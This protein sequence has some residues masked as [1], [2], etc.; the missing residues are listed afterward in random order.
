MLSSVGMVGRWLASL[1]L[2][3]PR[4]EL[5]MVVGSDESAGKS[6][7]SVRDKKERALQEH[8]GTFWKAYPCPDN[9]P[10][11]TIC[12][13]KALLSSSCELVFSSVHEKAGYL[14]DESIRDGRVV[15]SNSPHRRFD[16]RVA[17]VVPEVNGGTVG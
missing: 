8:Y 1:L 4:F 12:S 7:R 17:L 13:Y 16:E 5:D 10:D 9:F 3:H 6:Y 14:E 11:M 15:F 2:N